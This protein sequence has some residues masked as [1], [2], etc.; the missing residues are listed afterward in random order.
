MVNKRLQYLFV[1]TDAFLTDSEQ[2]CFD[3]LKH[4]HKSIDTGFENLHEKDLPLLNLIKKG[5]AD[6]FITPSSIFVFG[7]NDPERHPISVDFHVYF[8]E[9]HK[10]A[11]GSHVLKDDEKDKIAYTRGFI[12]N[13]VFCKEK[14]SDKEYLKFV[15]IF[16]SRVS[17]TL[18]FP[19]Y[20]LEQFK[21]QIEKTGMSYNIITPKYIEVNC[22]YCNTVFH[23]TKEGSTMNCPKCDSSVLVR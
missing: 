23:S 19:K 14:I 11:K 5:Y 2:K 17:Y 3:E 6:T 22:P 4:G 16:T 18:S 10:D 7:R 20:F 13:W 15:K 12:A 21:D 8:P 9:I 1:D